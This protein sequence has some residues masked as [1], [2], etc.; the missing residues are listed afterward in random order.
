MGLHKDVYKKYEKHQYHVK[1]IPN[2]IRSHIVKNQNLQDK[3]GYN[4]TI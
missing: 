4:Q 1:V 2:L 3:V